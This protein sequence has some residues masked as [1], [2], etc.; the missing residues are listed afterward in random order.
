MCVPGTLAWHLCMACLDL[1]VPPAARA[2]VSCTEVELLHWLGW[3]RGLMPSLQAEVE[4]LRR[5]LCQA[6]GHQQGAGSE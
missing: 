4:G 2:A 5:E 6:E 3:R 1:T